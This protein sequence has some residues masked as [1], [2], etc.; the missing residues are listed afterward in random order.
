MKVKLHKATLIPHNEPTYPHDPIPPELELPDD[1]T[2]VGV[3]STPT[4]PW[5][6]VYYTTPVLRPQVAATQ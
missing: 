1:A 6:T 3:Q 2:I 4:G 5:L